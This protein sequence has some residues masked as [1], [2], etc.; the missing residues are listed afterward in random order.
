MTGAKNELLGSTHGLG[1]F[2]P[3]EHQ[4]EIWPLEGR[5]AILCA[6][7]RISIVWFPNNTPPPSDVDAERRRQVLPHPTK[8]HRTRR[9]PTM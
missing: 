2:S 9:H 7:L 4:A 1:A 3:S 8:Q 5:R 6:K